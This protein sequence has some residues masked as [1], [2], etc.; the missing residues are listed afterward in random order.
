MVEGAQRPIGFGNVLRSVGTL[1][2]DTK[3]AG[4]VGRLLSDG[5]I[6]S[7]DFETFF[8]NFSRPSCEVLVELWFS[9]SSF[10]RPLRVAEV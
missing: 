7:D 1:R 2:D 9:E 3:D 4:E 6:P 10:R 8:E 5:A